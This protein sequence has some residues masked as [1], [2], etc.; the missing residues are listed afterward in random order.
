MGD[1]RMRLA[2]KNH[3]AVTLI[4]LGFPFSIIF[5]RSTKKH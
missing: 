3:L 4:A 2:F 5:L 1:L